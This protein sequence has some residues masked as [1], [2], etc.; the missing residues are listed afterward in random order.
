MRWSE[1]INR[2]INQS[3]N[4]STRKLVKMSELFTLSVSVWYVCTVG[5]TEC[6]S[7]AHLLL[8]KNEICLYQLCKS[9][10]AF[11]LSA[12]L[13]LHITWWD[14]N[15][16]YISIWQTGGEDIPES[17]VR[18]TVIAGNSALFTGCYQR[19]FDN[20]GGEWRVDA[21]AKYSPIVH[22]FHMNIQ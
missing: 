3:I 7:Y 20:E 8:T 21:N 2:S 12:R 5:H 10:F 11:I 18:E 13:V 15:G 14:K 4:K 19:W 17:L 9:A 22:F 1:I 6:T 16:D